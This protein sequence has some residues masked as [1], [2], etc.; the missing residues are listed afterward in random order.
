MIR[1]AD[2]RD[3]EAIKQVD[4]GMTASHDRGKLVREAIET[5]R[6]LVA[7]DALQVIGYGLIH[8]HFFGRSFVELIYVTEVERNR[9]WGPQ[10]L[11]G[12][13]ALSLSED[14]FTSTNE[15]NAHMQHVLDRCGYRRV[16]SI[17]ELDPGDPEIIY[18]K[19][20]H[21]TRRDQHPGV[22]FAMRRFEPSDRDA[23]QAIRQRAFQPV[24]D[25]FRRLLGDEIFRAEYDDADESQAGYLDSICQHESNVEVYVLLAPDRVIGFV[26]LSADVDRS[27]GEIDLNAVDPEHQGQGGGQFMY[28][29]ALRRLKE[30]GVSVVRVST[31]NDSSHGP[32][33]RAY[34]GVGFNAWVPSVTMYRLL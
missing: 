16:G 26:G 5:G 8:H 29:F 22:E 12:L 2:L 3:L 25:S 34:E 11:I 4:P 31:G 23:I 27:R 6:A 18:L 24:F 21:T 14:L 19:H 15:S 20:L 28:A 30:L 33:R 17:A 32:A 7:E 9:G 10:I 1:P 13:E